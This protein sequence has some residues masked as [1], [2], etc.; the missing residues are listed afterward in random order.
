M[1]DGDDYD[2]FRLGGIGAINP[3]Q[4]AID[5]E[6]L[7]HDV[8]RG[9][10]P[11]VFS[12]RQSHRWTVDMSVRPW[13]VFRGLDTLPF[14]L[15]RFTPA[16]FAD[17]GW[18]GPYRTNL[19]DVHLGLGFELRLELDIAYGFVPVLRAGWARGIGP[20]GRSQ[21]YLVLSTYP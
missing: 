18:I 11:N 7:G 3:V 4:Q 9:F 1:S 2:E 8:L 6:L 12:G 19:E 10:S 20:Q 21:A 16:I 13:E 17:L 14:A 15:R 5:L